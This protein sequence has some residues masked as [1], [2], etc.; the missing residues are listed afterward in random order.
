MAGSR[1]AK[2][3][4]Q[5]AANALMEGRQDDAKRALADLKRC[6]DES[7]IEMP[8]MPQ[9]VS[10]LWVQ[11]TEP[12][13]PR[14]S[15]VNGTTLMSDEARASLLEAGQI[16][17]QR[18]LEI[19]KDERLF[20]YA[21]LLTFEQQQSWVNLALQRGYGS[22]AAGAQRVELPKDGAPGQQQIGSTLQ[23]LVRAKQGARDGD[24]LV[25]GE[26][27]LDGGDVDEVA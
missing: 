26:L 27:A 11:I 24:G 4:V 7:G 5:D 8:E 12:L 10:E 25:D 2:K 3:A 18:L 9:Q 1:R 13:P 15:P 21:G 20:G 14:R 23:L 19:M 17:A 16:A 6:L 22:M